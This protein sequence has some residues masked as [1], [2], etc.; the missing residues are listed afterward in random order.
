[1]NPSPGNS[2]PSLL[3]RFFDLGSG[4]GGWEA[5]ELREILSLL[6]AAP[7][8]PELTKALP[9]EATF[10]RQF[11]EAATPPITA[12]SDLFQHANPPSELVDIVQHFA[13]WHLRRADSSLP[14]EVAKLIACSAIALSLVRCEG[15]KRDLDIAVA[16]EGLGWARR[17]TWIPDWLGDVLALAQ[18]S[19]A[20]DHGAS[21]P[22]ITGDV[23][24]LVPG[25]RVEGQLGQG[26]MGIVWRAIQKSTRRP[27]ALKLIGPAAFGSER[28]RLRFEREVELASRLEHPGIAR[29]YHSGNYQ[30][31]CFY[32]MELIEGRHLDRFVSEQKLAARQILELVRAICDAVQYA[33]QRGVIHRDLKPS[34]VLVTADGQP[35]IVDFGLAKGVEQAE[36]DLSVTEEGHFAGTLAFM[37]PEQ[38]AGDSD[39][40]DIRTDVYSLGALLYLLLV[41]DTLHDSH[42]ARYEVIHRI[43]HEEPR[44]PR[45]LNP[46][47]DAELE[48]LL[49]KAIATEPQERYGSAAELAAEIGRYLAGEPLTAR[50]H[51]AGYLAWKWLR[52]HRAAV[53][54]AAVAFLLILAAGI[55][56]SVRVRLERNR[57]ISTNKALGTTV[58]ELKEKQEQLKSADLAMQKQVAESLL[59]QADALLAAQ[60]CAAAQPVY[61]DAEMRFAKLGLPTLNAEMGESLADQSE[62]PAIAEWNAGMSNGD[63]IHLVPGGRYVLFTPAM[64]TAKTMDVLTGKTVARFPQTIGGIHTSAFSADGRFFVCASETSDL[65]LFDVMSGKI[66]GASRGPS[67]TSV[68]LGI[69]ATAVSLDGKTILYGGA[70]GVRKWTLAGENRTIALD[71]TKCDGGLWFAPGG[72]YFMQGTVTGF[73]L[74][75]VA[76]GRIEASIQI[77]ASASYFHKITAISGDEKTVGIAEFGK[78]VLTDLGHLNK[79]LTL[80]EEP[81]SITSIDFSPDGTLLASAGRDRTVKIWDVK[82]GKLI[83]TPDTGESSYA[84]PRDVRFSTDGVSVTI[85]QGNRVRIL[86][87]A[88]G[89][90][91]QTFPAYPSSA[92]L[93]N[94]GLLCL[95]GE[96]QA[97]L[98]YDRTTGIQFQICGEWVTNEPGPFRTGP[99]LISPNGKCALYAHGL[100][101]TVSLVDTRTFQELRKIELSGYS[102]YA[103][104]FAPDGKSAVFSCFKGGGDENKMFESFRVFDLQ[105]GKELCASHYPG[106]WPHHNTIWLADGKKILS[107]H[108]ATLSGFDLWDA[109]TGEVRNTIQSDP[110][111]AMAVAADDATIVCSHNDGQVQKRSLYDDSSV[112]TMGAHNGNVSAIRLFNHDRNAVSIGSDHTLRIWDLAAGG[113]MR[114]VPAVSA[115]LIATSPESDT[116]LL[117]GERVDDT[118]IWDFSR[119]KKFHDFENR[120]A[121]ARA[122][123]QKNPDDGEAELTIA[124]WL[125]FRGLW[126]QAAEF[127]KLSISHGAKPPHLSLAQCYWRLNRLADAKAEF[128]NALNAKGVDQD[129]L[130]TCIRGL[131]AA[132]ENLTTQ[133]TTRP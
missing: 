82:T 131:D 42:G 57:V 35:H 1:M 110:M 95:M 6:L 37:S 63:A 111:S 38:A 105:T 28:G 75:A 24:P 8:V 13:E 53:A 90:E 81:E 61:R 73:S 62:P 107:Y 78:I 74:R 39:R 83:R 119:P 66:L 91:I 96:D 130:R 60:Q 72:K 7:L 12:F 17:Q 11:A 129:Y 99:T 41:G 54:L 69:M 3:A 19:G 132:H 10:A 121:L 21:A 123:L 55:V 104:D 16:M 49:L 108:R 25:Y 79:Q 117:G 22:P 125:A 76:D 15:A 33:H 87:I 32:A 44:N 114:S 31:L 94:N 118:W 77:N 70:F 59:A 29:V 80:Q 71:N 40:I 56:D 92:S 34:N 98:G 50:P 52:R 5:D 27:V 112:V 120:L 46:G 51:S 109:H 124:Q 47:I 116:I 58:A 133:L 84:Y 86:P 115:D 113:E 122:A 36:G 4:E 26:G 23:G 2:D 101:P 88:P 103:E 45:K 48:T 102:L 106:W 100:P 126:I 9:D 93:S 20:Q 64:E 67:A 43:V 85:S 128:Q 97:I 127:Y 68:S 89:Q 14:A 65:T 18:S 30:G